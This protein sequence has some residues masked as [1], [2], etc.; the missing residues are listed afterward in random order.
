MAP[1]RSL[2]CH[3]RLWVHHAQ[4]V[5]GLGTSGQSVSVKHGFA[6][7]ALLPSGLGMALAKGA[8]QAAPGATSAAAAAAA[9]LSGVLQQL[10]SSAVVLVR[11][12]SSQLSQLGT[13]L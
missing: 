10:T 12:L 2:R 7:N 1:E 8:E 13:N 4:D 11:A 9:R 5:P 3:E 6:R